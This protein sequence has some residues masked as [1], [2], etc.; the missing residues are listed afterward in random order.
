MPVWGYVLLALAAVGSVLYLLRAHWIG[1]MFRLPEVSHTIRVHRNIAVQMSD[2]VVLMA[3]HYAPKSKD[4]LPAVLIRTPFGRGRGGLHGVS[5]YARRLAERGYHVVVQ[6]VRGRHQSEGRFDPFADESAD[7]RATLE[8][9]ARQSWYDGHCGMWGLDY[10]AWTQWAVAADAPEH[11]RALAPAMMSPDGFSSTWADGAFS[12]E[13]RLYWLAKL[14]VDA[15]DQSPGGRRD[16]AKDRINAWLGAPPEKLAKGFEALPL[17]E[18]DQ[19]V[20]GQEDQYWRDILINAHRDRP[21]WSARDHRSSL[22]KSPAPALILTGWYDYDLRGCIKS[23]GIMKSQGK[24]PHLV[25]GPWRHHDVAAALFHL[26]ESLDWFKVNLK[27]RKN[28]KR[29]RPVKVY[30]TGAGGWRELDQWPP[31]NRGVRYFLHSGQRLLNVNPALS[32][33]PDE[34][35]YDPSKPTPA[36]GGALADRRKAGPQINN[37]LEVRPDV[38]I[39]TSPVLQ[40]NLEIM[41]PMRLELYVRSNLEYT[42]FFGRL[43]QVQQNGRSINVCDGLYRIKPQR[44]TA[45]PDGSLKIVIDLASAAHVFQAGTYLRL[46]VS[47]GAH[48]RWARNLGLGEAPATATRMI[49][50]HHTVYHDALRPSAL[51]LPVTHVGAASEDADDLKPRKGHM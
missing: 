40:E 12:L 50:A 5:F 23:Y 36:V 45:Q 24:S 41:G 34:F 21:Y 4:P 51:V 14:K 19:A 46:Q 20:L 16:Q 48:P 13:S 31:P 27:G 43:C 10:G 11:L 18:A 2:G 42:D 7:G 38:L 32:S 44:G 33:P 6:D 35:V 49:K 22:Y 30:V 39:Y 26:R 29:T 9:I 17:L 47:G 28:K 37:R 25:I 3:D 1:F 8:W 15:P